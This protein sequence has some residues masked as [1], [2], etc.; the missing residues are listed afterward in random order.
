MR[1]CLR[2]S[3]AVLLFAR[4]FLILGACILNSTRDGRRERRAFNL[5][6]G[7]SANSELGCSGKDLKTIAPINDDHGIECGTLA[8]EVLNC[9]MRTEPTCADAIEKFKACAKDHV[10]FVIYAL[11][12]ADPLQKIMEFDL[13]GEDHVPPQSS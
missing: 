6:S 8:A 1:P 5:L 3:S 7:H 10:R 2:V 4:R 12:R 11:C 13:V 9:L